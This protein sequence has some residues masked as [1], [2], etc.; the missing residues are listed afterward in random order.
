MG[1]TDIPLSTVNST[2]HDFKFVVDDER[3]TKKSNY[4]CA[5]HGAAGLGMLQIMAFKCMVGTKKIGN[6]RTMPDEVKC[7]RISKFHVAQF[8]NFQHHHH[9]NINNNSSNVTGVTFS[10][11]VVTILSFHDSRPTLQVE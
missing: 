6:R 10:S 11:S 9:N 7:L 1:M 3:T 8:G 5:P 2:D 4:I